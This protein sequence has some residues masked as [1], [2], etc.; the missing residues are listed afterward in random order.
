[1]S[2]GDYS[3]YKVTGNSSRLNTNSNAVHKNILYITRPDMKY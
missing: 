3:V 2:H 1:M